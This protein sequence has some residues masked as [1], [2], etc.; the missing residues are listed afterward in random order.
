MQTFLLDG[1]E[2]NSTNEDDKENNNSNDEPAEQKQIPLEKFDVEI[3]KFEAIHKTIM[4]LDS[5]VHFHGWFR[6]DS[7][8]LKQSLNVIVKK[9]SY[10]LT[11]YLCDVTIESL[12][13]AGAFVST[14]R[15]GLLS[16]I[17][18]GNFVLWR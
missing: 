14:T 16:K 6:V 17:P 7:K 10:T 13:D 1:T 2:S 4:G 5:E 18:E 9:W 11:K 3:R 15:Q 8:P 12:H